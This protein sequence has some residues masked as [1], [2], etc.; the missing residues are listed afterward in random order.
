MHVTLASATDNPDF[1]PEPFS[2]L[3][4][5]SLYQSMRNLVGRTFNTLQRVVDGLPASD[6][7]QAGAVLAFRSAILERMRKLV[8]DKMSARRIRTHG[9][10]HLGQVL[11]TGRDFVIID[12]EGEPARPLT[13]RRLKRSPLGDVA[14][15]LRSF[16]YAAHAAIRSEETRGLARAEQL[17]GIEQWAQVWALWASGAFLGAYLDTARDAGFLPEDD[18]ELHTLLEAHLLE[19][20]VYELG[21]ELNNRPDWV[22]TP[23]RGIRHLLGV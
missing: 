7:E 9:D 5:R 19:K 21:Y 10:Y 13:E 8:G 17:E 1:A 15:M 2:A 18:D 16:H 14:G 4:Q 23:V 22:R 20:A 12:F 6:R 3:Y 11:F